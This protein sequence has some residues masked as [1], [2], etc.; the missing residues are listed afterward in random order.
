MIAPAATEPSYD[1]LD[2]FPMDTGDE[3]TYYIRAGEVSPVTQEKVFIVQDKDIYSFP[4][5]NIFHP[6]SG[7]I[8][9]LKI[10]VKGPFRGGQ[11]L[12]SV[13]LEILKDEMGLYRDTTGIYWGMMDN[14]MGW[15]VNAMQ[16]AASYSKDKLKE[17]YPYPELEQA[18]LIHSYRQIF[19][20]DGYQIEREDGE[21]ISFLGIDNNVVGY[22]GTPC[23]H[24][25]REV[26]AIKSSSGFN[27]FTEHT[28]Y[29]KGKGMVRLEQKING[30]TS[31]VWTLEKF[32]P[33][34]K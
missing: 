4:Y 22:H 23:Y 14:P 29:V 31:M 16:F 28:W 33:G 18:S 26:P 34:G 32:T 10:R 7:Q 2:Y 8:Y 24:F 19:I 25:V 21:S 9:V 6:V 11:R 5:R 30:I 20:W 13:D 3:W 15:G 27:A 12:N 17:R 1:A